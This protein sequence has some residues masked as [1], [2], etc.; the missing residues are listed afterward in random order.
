MSVL[1]EAERCIV[2]QQKHA[3]LN[4]FITPLQRSGPWLDSVRDADARRQHG[5]EGSSYALVPHVLFQK[6]IVANLN[7]YGD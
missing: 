7:F 3:G 4:A 5:K 6:E 1:R 2:N